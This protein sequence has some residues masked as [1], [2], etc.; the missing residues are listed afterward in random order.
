MREPLPD[1]VG[2]RYLN[3]FNCCYK[4][5]TLDVV[6]W[7]SAKWILEGFKTEDIAF[8]DCGKFQV[9]LYRVKVFKGIDYYLKCNFPISP[10]VH[11]LSVCHNFLKGGEFHLHVSIGAFVFMEIDL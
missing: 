6:A 8:Q 9:H 11:S 1:M 2:I 5:K 10:H 4:Q 7:S 3:F